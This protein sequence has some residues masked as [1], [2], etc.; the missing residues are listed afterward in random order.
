MMIDNDN[1]ML[2]KSEKIDLSDS[3]FVCKLVI[4]DIFTVLSLHFGVQCS[5]IVA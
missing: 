3:L 5:L 4:D 1:D 2:L